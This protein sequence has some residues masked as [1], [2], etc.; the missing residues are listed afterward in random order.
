MITFYVCMG[1]ELRSSD[2]GKMLWH[3]AGL[4]P[5]LSDVKY[6]ERL[7]KKA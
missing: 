2:T 1:K 6:P 7:L 4:L 3:E 5:S